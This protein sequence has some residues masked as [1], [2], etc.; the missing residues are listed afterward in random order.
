MVAL[1]YGARDGAITLVLLSVLGGVGLAGAHLLAARRHRLGSLR[2]QFALGVGVA[3]GNS[4][5]RSPPPP[6]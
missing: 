2:R 3:V 5:S 4:S 1:A 6:R